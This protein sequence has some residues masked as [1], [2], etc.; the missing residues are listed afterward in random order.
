MKWFSMIL[1]NSKMKAPFGSFLVIRPAGNGLKQS[2]P[3]HM[4]RK[5]VLGRGMNG[6]GRTGGGAGLCQQICSLITMFCSKPV[7]PSKRMNSRLSKHVVI[8]SLSYKS[9]SCLRKKF[10]SKLGNRRV[11]QFIDMLTQMG[12]HNYRLS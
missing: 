8:L 9:N 7:C 2:N 3:T 6:A 4:K 11:G 10:R 12:Y 5:E 1:A